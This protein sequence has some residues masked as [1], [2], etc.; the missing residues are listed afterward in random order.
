MPMARNTAQSRTRTRA[1]HF[2]AGLLGAGS[3][4]KGS[5]L[6]SEVSW[7]S[8]AIST[9]PCCGHGTQEPGLLAQPMASLVPPET[10]L[11]MSLG[12]PHDSLHS[13]HAGNGAALI[14]LYY[15]SHP[16]SNIPLENSLSSCHHKNG[17]QC[18][19]SSTSSQA[20]DLLA[21]GESLYLTP[22]W[23]PFVC[24]L[25]LVPSQWG[26]AGR[27]SLSLLG[28]RLRGSDRISKELVCW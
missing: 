3:V 14:S 20:A 1:C 19:G 11:G 21:Y 28:S 27:N 25:H 10:C 16:R 7:I 15:L 12:M 13:S 5:G 6:G 23:Q 17:L 24:A 22:L 9:L 8:G 2:L 18:S 4:K 26:G